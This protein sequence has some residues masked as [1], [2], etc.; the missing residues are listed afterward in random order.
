ML[1]A[2]LIADLV[3]KKYNTTLSGATIN[4]D[5]ASL[6]AMSTLL[7]E[8][9]PGTPDAIAGTIGSSG[10]SKL[11]EKIPNYDSVTCGHPSTA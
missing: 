5:H 10:Q 1:E 4:T 11:D 6:F 7:Y 3:Q 8:I 2:C 9:N